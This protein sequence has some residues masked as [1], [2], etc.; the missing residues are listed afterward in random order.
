MAS[1][2]L[3]DS[4]PCF[5]SAAS[6]Q[7]QEPLRLPGQFSPLA[8]VMGLISV[9]KHGICRSAVTAHVKPQHPR[10]AILRD[11]SALLLLFLVTKSC[12]TLLR[13]Q[14]L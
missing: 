3:A 11:F 9:L 7:G 1:P 13:P 4:T 10:S 14:G 8:S 2:K 6:F 12:P 5:C